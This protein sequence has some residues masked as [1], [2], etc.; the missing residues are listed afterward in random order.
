VRGRRAAGVLLA[1]LL[2]T[3]GAACAAE[4]PPP[5][6]AEPRAVAFVHD[7]PGAHPRIP[8]LEAFARDIGAASERT[9]AVRINPQGETLAGRASLD[10]VRS[11]A[12]HIAAVNM[13]HLE[14]LEPQA[15]FMNLPFGLNDTTMADASNR[16]AVTEILADALRP[17]GVELLGIMR[18]ADQ[19]FAF[20]RDDVHVLEDLAGS[21]IRV[22]GGGIYEQV[23][24][25]LGAE[26]VAIPIPQIRDAMSRGE[27][28]GVFTSPGG[29]TSEVRGDAPHAVQVPGLMLITY[30][31]VA[32]AAWL[33]SLTAAER[34]AVVTAGSV[35]TAGWAAMQ[36]DD[37]MVVAAATADGSTYRV[38]SEA[39][40]ARW[41]DAVADVRAGFL[42][43][44]PALAERLRRDG[45]VG[46]P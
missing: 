39:E 37:E 17:H 13:A 33:A 5:P 11:G 3:T 10:A 31:V 43:G 7:L 35:V 30:G 9:L 28:D 46:G 29:W 6:D 1:G 45:L 25:D 2:V 27:V 38:L 20:P 21:R 40:T 12:A 32:D 15:G 34:D 14:A 41:A 22:A 8:Y 4:P 16:A 23:L 44:Q 24:R 19:L 18:G 42:A 36:R 26:P